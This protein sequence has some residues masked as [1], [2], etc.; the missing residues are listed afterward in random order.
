VPPYSTVALVLL[1]LLPG[2]PAA[3][4]LAVAPLPVAD[5]DSVG[6]VTDTLTLELP[7][8]DVERELPPVEVE[9]DEPPPIAVEFEPLVEPL[10]ELLLVPMLLLLEP[11]PCD[12]EVEVEPDVEPE[13]D[14]EPEMISACARFAAERAIKSAVALI[15]HFIFFS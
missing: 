14:V 12:V 2:S 13:S 15:A 11:A 4:L 8:A 5:A 9:R 7:P 1:G 3:A 6:K 10:D